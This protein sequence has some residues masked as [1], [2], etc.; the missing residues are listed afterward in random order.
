MIK[1]IKIATIL[2][3]KENYTVSKAQAA[4][5]WVSDFYKFSKFK[6]IITYSETQIK[7]II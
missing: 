1:D 6:K 4:A 3:Y 7:K 2:P 5:L